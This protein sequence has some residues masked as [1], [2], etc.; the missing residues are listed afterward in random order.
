MRRRDFITLLAALPAAAS[1]AVWTLA[2]RAQPGPARRIGVLMGLVESDPEAQP[3]VMAFQQGLQELGWVDDRNLRIDYRWAGSDAERVRAGAKEL[4][5]LQPDVIVGSS[6]VVV[7]ALLRETRTIPIVFVTTAD[8]VGDGFVDSLARPGRNATGF[9]SNL[10]S[11]GGKWL[12]LLRELAPGVMRSAVMFNPETAP[13]GGSYYLRPLEAAAA[14][15]A[16]KFAATPVRDPGQIESAIATVGG[17]PGGSLIVI[18]DTFTTV[19][20]GVIMSAAARHRVPA[21]YPFR[22]FA[23][24][25]GLMSYGADLTDLYRRTA[26]YVDRILKGAK[27]AELPVQAPPKVELVI[28]LRTAR[29]LG[30]TVPRIMLARADEVVE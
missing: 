11:I 27:P 28:N 5:A 3:R 17:E 30:L 16:V 2:A 4:V 8:P 21:V 24:E 14:S 25:G 13:G 12:E 29:T 1:L 6:S 18:P 9:T 19:H 15:M 23:R 10:A 7:A 26:S 22:Y 20:R